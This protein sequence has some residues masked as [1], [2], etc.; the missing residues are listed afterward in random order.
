MELLEMIMSEEKVFDNWQAVIVD[1]FENKIENIKNNTTKSPKIPCKLYKARK[2][3]FDANTKVAK[4]EKAKDKK[5]LEG[6]KKAISEKQK[7]L[8]QLRKDAPKTEIKDWIN[9]NHNK[10]IAEGKRII[11]ATHVLKF[12]HTSSEAGGLLLKDKSDDL[13]LSTASLKRKLASDLAHNNGALISLSR[14]LGLELNGNQIIDCVLQ[15]NFE[16]LTP[17]KESKTQLKEWQEG[18]SNLVEIRE[19]KTADKAKQLYFPINNNLDNYHLITPLFASS[20][21]NEVDTIISN[22]KYKE[23]KEINKYKNHKKSPKYYPSLYVDYPNIAAQNFDK[24]HPNNVSMLNADR[25]GKSYLF[26]TQPPTWQS[27]LKPPIDKGNMFDTYRYQINTREN[28]KYLVEFLLRFENIDLSIRD[29]KKLEWIEKWAGYIIDDFLYFVA[30]IHTL[31]SGWSAEKSVKLKIEHQYLLDPDRNDEKFK[32][33]RKETDWQAV[34][35][36]DFSTWLNRQLKYKNEK[37]TPQKEYSKIWKE[38]MGQELREYSQIIIANNE[39][40]Q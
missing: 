38:L 36:I 14:F 16:F 4:L 10:K 8:I 24:K 1:F 13:L 34:V 29:P 40:E 3:I 32:A 2:Y 20:L 6:Y 30:T 17:F 27:Q 33:N 35:V 39:T 28:I 31:P 12:T 22:L 25:G 37:F 7:E 23:Q 19:M 5:K 21:C 18:F 11:K 26:S 9:L 15:N